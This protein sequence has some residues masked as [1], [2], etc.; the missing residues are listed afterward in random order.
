MKGYDIDYSEFKDY[1]R[2]VT[3]FVNEDWFPKIVEQAREFFLKEARRLCPVDSG[4]LKKSLKC[5]S[6]ETNEGYKITLSSE[7]NYGSFVEYGTMY[8]KVGSPENPIPSVKQG[9][10]RPFARPALIA[11]VKFIEKEIDKKL[12]ELE[13]K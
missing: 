11:T 3:A 7:K 13:V 4:E 12:K 5:E 8:I 9:Q 6:E 1:V 2:I 10:Y